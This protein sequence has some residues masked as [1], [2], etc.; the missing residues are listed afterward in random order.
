MSNG[1][2]FRRRLSENQ[3]ALAA[4]LGPLDGAHIPGGCQRCDAYQTVSPL[5]AGAWQVT[6]HHDDWCPVLAATASP[7]PGAGR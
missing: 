3:Q 2:R 4:I 1:R 5:T 7:A 6:V